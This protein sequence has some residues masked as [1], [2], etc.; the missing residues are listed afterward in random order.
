[1]HA[2]FRNLCGAIFSVNSDEL[3]ARAFLGYFM[4]KSAFK[5]YGFCPEGTVGIM[6]GLA[7]SVSLNRGA[8]WLNAEVSRLH[9]ADG[10]VTSATVVRD[11]R[12]VTVEADVFVSNAGPAATVVM[13]GEEHFGEEYL[14]MMKQRLRPVSIFAIHIAS[15]EPLSKYPGIVAFGIT[16]RLCNLCN[17]T[18]TCPELAPP[19]QHLA[20]AYAVPVPSMG[21]FDAEAEIALALQDLRDQ[22]K[23]F[24]KIAR[25]LEVETRRGDWPGQ[26]SGHGY[27]LPR[28]TPL[29]NLWNVGDAV[30]EFPNG[31]TEG[32]AETGK[33]VVEQVLARQPLP[34]R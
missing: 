5:H 25:V 6:Q 12:E 26:R 4:Q 13:T 10:R 16:K 7:A 28:E 33:L 29:A 20:V 22:Y 11:G 15:T 18:A 3:P 27:E 31:G 19:G 8:V 34:A 17:L 2:I 32:C 24:D 1:M 21:D 23:N 14:T 9:V 30:R